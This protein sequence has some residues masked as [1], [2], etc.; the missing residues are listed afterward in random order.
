MLGARLGLAL[1]IV[2]TGCASSDSTSGSAST[3]TLDREPPFE[4]W[5]WESSLGVEVAVPADW[6]INEITDGC[7]IT[8]TATV[9]RAPG[10]IFGC[11]STEPVTKQLVEIK[12]ERDLRSDDAASFRFEQVS[13][14][15]E[16]AERGEGVMPDGRASGR[17]R[18][19]GIGVIIDAR[20]KEIETLRTV[21]DSVRIVEVD[22][23]ACA[24]SRASMTALPPRAATFLPSSTNAVSVCGYTVGEVLG[25]SALIDGDA[26]IALVA[27]LNQARPGRN[28]DIP[29]EACLPQTDEPPPDV[30]LVAHGAGDGARVEV[31]FSSCKH[32]G[33]GN[34]RDEAQLT[35]TLLHEIM[36]PLHSGYDYS[37]AGLR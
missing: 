23:N 27:A 6:G 16:P 35:E 26:A 29:K 32:R 34:G 25:A 20:V 13:V 8:D 37:P 21:F 14:G 2:A 22:H 24:T 10:M 7:L 4:G 5:R 36:N 28:I 9:V 11:E 15:T 12:R 1:L 33:M 31:T 19:P 17:L 30:V 18:I 3:G